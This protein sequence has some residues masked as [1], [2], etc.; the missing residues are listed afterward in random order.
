MNPAAPPISSSKAVY[1][2]NAKICPPTL[3]ASAGARPLCYGY[4][5]MHFLPAITAS[6]SGQTHYYGH[7]RCKKTTEV[8][9]KLL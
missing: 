1:R 8:V 2:L 5:Q 3:E 9:C 4:I 6:H 7:R